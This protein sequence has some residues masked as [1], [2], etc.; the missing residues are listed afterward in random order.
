M[1]RWVDFEPWRERQKELL[2]EAER[3]RLRPNNPQQP[4]RKWWRRSL[5]LWKRIRHCFIKEF[6]SYGSLAPLR[7]TDAERHGVKPK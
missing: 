2:R 7:L 3:R 5:G 1:D 6:R 4:G